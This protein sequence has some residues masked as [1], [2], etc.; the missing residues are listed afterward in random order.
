MNAPLI[1]DHLCKS[2]GQRDALRHI[3]LTLPTGRVAGFLGRNGAGKSTLL[4]VVCGLLLPSSGTCTTLGRPAGELDAPELNRLG[5]VFQEG[6][7][8]DWMSV[9]QHLAFNGSMYSTWDKARESRLLKELELDPTRKISELSPG[10]RQKLGIILGVCHH[11]ALLLLDEPMSALD[12][13]ARSTMLAFLVDLIREDECTVVISSHILSDVEK[14][15]DWVI[16]LDRGEL[17]TNAPL[18]ELQEGYAEWIVTSTNGALPAQF[19]EPW[20]LA[21]TGDAR[22]ARLSVRRPDEAT[23]RQFATTHHLT[24]EPHYVNLE[25]LFPL[26]IGERKGEA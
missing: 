12:P 10:D 23:E 20:V 8:L 24:I 1:A 13:V 25:Q 5:V 2:F 9:A 15:V 4:H 11:P 6:R 26:L 16:C 22:R 3:S 17:R 21:Q 19:S 18:D 7:F 14:I